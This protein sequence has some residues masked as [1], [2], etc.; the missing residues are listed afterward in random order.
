LHVIKMMPRW[1]PGMQAGH[2]V[3]MRYSVPVV[4]KLGN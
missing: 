4:F 3:R 1:R 2:A